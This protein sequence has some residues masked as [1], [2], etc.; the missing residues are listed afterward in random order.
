MFI[1]IRC[2]QCSSFCALLAVSGRRGGHFEYEV[3]LHCD[4]GFVFD[5][6]Q[7][8]FTRVGEAHSRLPRHNAEEVIVGRRSSC[9]VSVLEL[10][11]GL[12]KVYVKNT[13]A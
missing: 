13:P 10:H 9:M 3:I 7:Q 1:P 8:P 11:Y 4:L 12:S 5:G 6:F 2:H